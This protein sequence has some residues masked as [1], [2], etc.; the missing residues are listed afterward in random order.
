ASMLFALR[1]M[2]LIRLDL[3]GMTISQLVSLASAAAADGRLR[4]PVADDLVGLLE[5]A[6]EAHAE[7]GSNKHRGILRRSLNTV[8]NKRNGRLI[9]ESVAKVFK[10]HIGL[11]LPGNNS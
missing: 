4:N 5:Q 7:G 9:D 8:T 2:D 3:P 6:E 11:M 1:E 10:H